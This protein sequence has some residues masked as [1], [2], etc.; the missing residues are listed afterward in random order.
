MPERP[1]KLEEFLGQERVV[2]GLDMAVRAHRRLKEISDKDVTFGHVMLS[3]GA[4]LGKTTLARSVLPNELGCESVA[5]NCSGIDNIKEFTSFMAAVPEGAIA[6]LDEIHALP[7]AAKEQLLS[8]LEDQ[9]MVVRLDDKVIP[10]ELPPFTV[11]AASTRIGALDAPLISRFKFKFTL[12]P[13]SEEDMQLV[14]RWHA[15]KL[16]VNYE[17]E[18]LKLLARAAKGIARNGVV[19][20]ENAYDT[21]LV[22]AAELNQPISEAIARKTLDRMGYSIVNGVVL[23]TEECQI[24]SELREGPLGLRT[25]SAR[26][27]ESPENIENVHETWL[28]QNGYVNKN[29]AGRRL[30]DKGSALQEGI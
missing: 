30:T 19:L 17:A 3:G 2:W 22:E 13:Y 7:W 26:L 14:I 4:G 8:V 6:F 10:V 15:M 29:S 1:K 27:N 16:G 28:V 25:L 5:I 9:C 11:V 18:G 21:L 12:K 20:L 24:L 23:T